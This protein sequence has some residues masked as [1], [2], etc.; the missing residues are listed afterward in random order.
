M[1]SLVLNTKI[2]TKLPKDITNITKEDIYLSKHLN[3]I[4]YKDDF[5]LMIDNEEEFLDDYYDFL[6]EIEISENN[7]LI[8]SE[9]IIVNNIYQNIPV[10]INKIYNKYAFGLI[11]NHTNVYIPKKFI[12]NISLNELVS[13]NILYNKNKNNW[14]CVSLNRKC[15]PILIN[16]VNIEKKILY[17]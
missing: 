11:N 7:K 2:N 3:I 9:V 4:D 10:R 8:E 14:K 15:E 17:I 5:D 13:M 6:R 1:D 16:S 12:N